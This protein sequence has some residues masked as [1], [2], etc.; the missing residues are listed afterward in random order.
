MLKRIL[1]TVGLAILS[2]VM[3]ALPVLAAYSA[4][5]T[6]VNNSVNSYT[7]IPLVLTQD[8]GYLAANGYIAANGLDVK[9]KENG[10]E[11]PLMLTDK[12]TWFVPS[13]IPA[14]T[15][16]IYQW[17]SGNT[18]STSKNIIVGDGG[19]GTT[20]DNDDLEPGNSFEININGYINTA[21]ADDKNL[22]YKED[23]FSLYVG[24]EEQLTATIIRNDGVRIKQSGSGYPYAIWNHDATRCLMTYWDYDDEIQYLRVI[25]ITDDGARVT[26]G[27]PIEMLDT[28]FVD[29][30]AISASQFVMFCMTYSG[31]VYYQ[32]LIVGTLS[33]NGIT[34]G[35]EQ[36]VASFA[37]SVSEY[38]HVIA[39]D[40]DK[41]AVTYYYAEDQMKL[42]VGTVSGTVVTLG[43][44]VEFDAD[45]ISGAFVKKLDT[46]KGVVFY[47]NTSDDALNVVAFTVS[48]TTPSFGSIE[49]VDSGNGSVCKALEQITTDKFVTGWEP[50]GDGV[51]CT[52][53]TVSGTTISLGT[54]YVINA[55]GYSLYALPVTDDAHFYALYTDI[56]TYAQMISYNSLSGTV[57]TVDGTPG[58]LNTV[59]LTDPWWISGC[60]IN[61]THI[62]AAI[63]DYYSD[64]P[65]I[66]HTIL[67]VIPAGEYGVTSSVAVIADNVS[68][69]VHTVKVSAD[70]SMFHIFID[71]VLKDSAP[72]GSLPGYF[73]NSN[74]NAGGTWSYCTDG[75]Y[76]YALTA[77]PSI[78]KINM[79]DMSFV[80]SF[81]WEDAYNA[82]LTGIEDEFDD[83]TYMDG[84]LY[85]SSILTRYI[86]VKVNAT[87]MSYVSY[88]EE[89]SLAA[90][91]NDR[92]L[93][94]NDGTYVYIYMEDQ[95]VA[96]GHVRKISSSLSEV[97][98][99]DG[100]VTARE[101]FYTQDMTYLDGYL[102]LCE[103]IWNSTAYNTVDKINVSSMTLTDQIKSSDAAHRLYGII[104]DGTYLYAHN[105]SGLFYKIDPSDLSEFD[106]Y[107]MLDDNNEQPLGVGYYDG[108]LYI[109]GRS[110]DS[111]YDGWL[112]VSSV[113]KVRVSDMAFIVDFHDNADPELSNALSYGDVLGY[114]NFIY[115][116]MGQ[117][118]VILKTS[119]ALAEV[120]RYVGRWTIQYETVIKSDADYIYLLGVDNTWASSL[121]VLIK[122][123]AHTL[124]YVDSICVDISGIG[125]GNM[126]MDYDG[127]YLY[128][129]VNR[130]DNGD[131]HYDVRL[132]KVDPSD[133]SVVDTFDTD[134]RQFA[135]ENRVLI[136]GSYVY[137]ARFNTNPL[138]ASRVYKVDKTTMASSSYWDSTSTTADRYVRALATDNT[139]LY[140]LSLDGSSVSHIRKIDVSSMTTDSTWTASHSP[141]LMTFDGTYL[142]VDDTTGADQQ[143]KSVNPATMTTVSTFT[144]DSGSGFQTPVQIQYIN[145]DIY[146]AGESEGIPQVISY[147]VAGDSWTIYPVMGNWNY[148]GSYAALQG[149]GNVGNDAVISY[150]INMTFDLGVQ[151]LIVSGT[152]VPPNSN[153]WTWD[154]GDVM[155]YMSYIT[156]AVDEAEVLEY[157]PNAIL[158]TIEDTDTGTA[159]FTTN[160]ATIVGDAT[161]WTSNMMGG[162][163]KNDTDAVYYTIQSVGS[164]TSLTL[165]S[166][167]AQTGGVSAAYTLNYYPTAT[168]PDRDGTEDGVITFGANPDLGSTNFVPNEPT[169]T[170]TVPSGG[171]Y[172]YGT[173]SS[174]PPDMAKIP[175]NPGGSIAYYSG[176]VA[177]FTDGSN[178]VTGNGTTWI[179]T[180]KGGQIK[181]DA[182]DVYYTIAGVTSSGNL[183]LTTDYVETGGTGVYHMTYLVGGVN[184]EDTLQSNNL[185]T[186]WFRPWADMSNI[187]LIS[188]FLFLGTAVLVGIVIWVMK[189]TQNQFVGSLVMLTG[190]SFLYKMGIY[191]LWFVI[192]TGLICI[193][194]II[195]E[196]KPSL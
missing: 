142:Y 79:S 140:L 143:I 51:Y 76:L 160:S 118:N 191:E 114:Q 11:L 192:V 7:Q 125:W 52:V 141:Y 40:T 68:S 50:S 184:A 31:G 102:Y 178:L 171:S 74:G 165:T 1:T 185:L 6:V 130:Y 94:D 84:Y 166:T 133:L 39:V 20:P 195:Y 179:S 15:S 30:C 55:N 44:G 43:T 27:T 123:D 25:S 152:G 14:S 82:G 45:E 116:G 49:E 5:I 47:G 138:V 132:Y 169:I 71:D 181:F 135:S 193:A 113:T 90:D 72:I 4:T 86:V 127:T 117:P 67:E 34:L 17:S 121:P 101:G 64:V 61:G 145:G 144:D 124:T 128:V 37:G 167:Y 156:M 80:D 164:A 57:V 183:S 162:Q 158:L 180:M 35:E 23:A 22:L 38:G 120:G 176:G 161:S 10:V 109:L 18:P 174:A 194:L 147:N 188:F 54:D 13:S 65:Y 134:G 16:H 122:L 151:Y 182:D 153:D 73:I 89:D 48:G 189:Q 104:N 91:A 24:A 88:W 97:G 136:V 8:N 81:T 93:V 2:I 29:G 83:L 149:L 42:A 69:G 9:I 33:G 100:N 36:L 96:I 146:F 41:I 70:G 62:V 108:Y 95:S 155:P 163:I 75:S 26:F 103:N 99:W 168:L 175:Y 85:F 173:Y 148:L 19:Y 60:S 59:G 78:I 12:Q 32:Y 157:R 150:D 131:G 112:D 63:D 196:R 170:P 110:T 154:E 87:T 3:I 77:Y 137:V 105:Y 111:F 177:T 28:F 56:N 187:P 186:P 58:S 53:G 190:E 139:Y 21:F 129:T 98:A 115:C 92:T 46:D 119:V 66:E 106:T 126:D 172:L 159:T 107:N